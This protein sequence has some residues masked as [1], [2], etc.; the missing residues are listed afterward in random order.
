MTEFVSKEIESELMS[1]TIF[2]AL[3]TPVLFFDLQFTHTQQKIYTTKRCW[4]QYIQS[5]R[6]KDN[7][8]FEA[9]T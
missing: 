6:K 4:L 1:S 9:S 2:R 7:W 8:I 3:L 5:K